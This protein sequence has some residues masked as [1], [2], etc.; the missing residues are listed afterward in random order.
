MGKCALPEEDSMLRR[1]W[2]PASSACA[3]CKNTRSSDRTKSLRVSI[4]AGAWV[5]IVG[6]AW[7]QTPPATVD[8][9]IGAA[10]IAAENP[11]NNTYW[12]DTFLIT[13]I[14]FPSGYKSAAENGPPPPSRLLKKILGG[15]S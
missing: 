2:A 5:A 6:S 1:Y 3:K 12:A 13:C 11:A 9:Y 10:K 4:L 15:D 8:E 14:P 7:T